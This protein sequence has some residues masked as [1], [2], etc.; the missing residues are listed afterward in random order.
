MKILNNK[1]MKLFTEKYFKEFD[2]DIKK[3]SYFEYNGKIEYLINDHY[4]FVVNK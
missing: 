1:E 3:V 2:Y 4:I